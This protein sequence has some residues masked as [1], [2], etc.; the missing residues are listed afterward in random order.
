MPATK[1]DA[2]KKKDAVVKVP[3]QQLPT[4]LINSMEDLHLFSQAVFKS[5]MYTGIKNPE[6]AMVRIQAGRE[7]GLQPMMAL[8][9]IHVLPKGDIVIATLVLG[10]VAMAQGVRW[11]I[12]QKNKDGCK[13]RIYSL[14]GSIPEHVETF[15]MEDAARADL[16]RKDNFQMYP[17]E[18]CYNRCLSKGLKVFDPRIGA[19]F[20]T[21]EEM[22]DIDHFRT[23]VKEVRVTTDKYIGDEEVKEAEVV[24]EEEDYEEAVEEALAQPNL[25]E[26]SEETKQMLKKQEEPAQKAQ[27][28]EEGPD[29]NYTKSTKQFEEN[30]E[31][32]KKH[33]EVLQLEES[34]FKQHLAGKQKS[35]R[36][37]GKNQYGHLS[38]HCGTTDAIAFLRENAQ[39]FSRMYVEDRMKTMQPGEMI[40][41]FV[42]PEPTDD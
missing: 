31:Q 4:P 9:K 1:K 13:L 34:D 19:G 29:P 41:C 35:K 40:G 17:E 30:I 26:A 27:E 21:K 11:Q 33:L 38:F 2:P 3:E 14:D 37:V 18:M 42:T 15:T 20:Y 6:T 39:R 28:E 23:E 25:D 7:L 12:L 32:I 24:D 36:F 8:N 5:N 16:A 10:A 22:E